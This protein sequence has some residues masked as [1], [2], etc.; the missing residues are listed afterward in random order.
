MNVDNHST[1]PIDTQTYYYLGNNFGH[2]MCHTHFENAEKAAKHY[3]KSIKK[4]NYPVFVC[5]HT[6]TVGE[7]IKI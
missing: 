6:V 5:K 2:A 7:E 1:T 3:K 4:L